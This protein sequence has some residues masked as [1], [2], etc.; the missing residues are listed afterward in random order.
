MA[1]L[2]SPRNPR[3]QEIRRAAAEGRPTED[4]LIVAEGPHLVQEAGRSEWTVEQVFATPEARARH[5]GL[6]AEL[7][8]EIIEIPSRAFAAISSTQHTQE[9]LALL[10]PRKWPWN[11]VSA[12]ERPLLLV[13]DGIQDPGNAG[14]MVR[15]AEAFGATGIV[16]LSGCARVANGKFLRATAGSIFRVPFLEG[17][18]I[19]E[20][21]EKVRSSGLK[22]YALDP[23]AR[24]TIIEADMRSALALV[25]GNEG[26]GVSPAFAARAQRI[27]IP[28]GKVESLNAAMA[29]SIALFEAHRKR[30]ST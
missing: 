19:D 24:A 22:L 12:T 20:V 4:G 15:S 10:R 1:Q 26:Q 21:I 3:L 23:G 13:L 11:D 16:F 14:T 18:T 29:C 9:V 17:M 8:A 5:A 27:S 28:T 25:V 6:L 30:N 2:I 7:D